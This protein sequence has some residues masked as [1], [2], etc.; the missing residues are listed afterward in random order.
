MGLQTCGDRWENLQ[1][2]S[3]KRRKKPR[4]TGITMVMDKGIGPRAFLDLMDTAGDY[5]DF[6]KLGFGTIA[7]TPEPLLK[8]KIQWSKERDI[9]LYPGGTFF[10]IAFKQGKTEHYLNHLRELGIEWVEISEGTIDLPVNDRQKIIQRA[11][12][13][14]FHVIT[15]IGKKTTDYSFDLSNWVDL[16]H[17]D[18]ASGASY[19]IMEGR[20]TGRF[21][22]EWVHALGEK[23][24]LRSVIWE[25]PQKDQQTY[26]IQLL[27]HHANFGNIPPQEV[28]ALECLRRGLRSDTFSLFRG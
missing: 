20:E 17:Q 10:E 21:H 23:I 24:D 18:R 2:L 19:V 28:I 5:I 26:I 7:I 9:H 27:G 13:L 3:S 1:D 16:Y 25:A 14:G 22:L 15:E 12:E 4:R 11:R 6:V 8:Q